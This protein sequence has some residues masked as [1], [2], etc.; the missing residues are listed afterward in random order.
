MLA[1]A[2]GVAGLRTPQ[3]K[4]HSQGTQGTGYTGYHT[5]FRALLGHQ[6]GAGL[7]P[8]PPPPPPPPPSS[9]SSG[10]CLLLLWLPLMIQAL[11]VAVVASVVVQARQGL[12]RRR[13]NIFFVLVDDTGWNNVGYHARSNAAGAEVATPVLDRLVAEGVELTRHVAFKYCSPSRCALQ[14]GRNPIHV[15]VDNDVFAANTGI[16]EPMTCLAEKL[17]ATYVRPA[18]PDFWNAS[19]RVEEWLCGGRSGYRTVF[20]GKWHAGMR[21][22]GQTPR[23]RGYQAAL[24]YFNPDNG[25]FA[26]AQ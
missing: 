9:S 26:Q 1:A 16:P 22:L 19:A 17:A 11:L 23:A 8:P 2:G 15:N 10:R 7:L 18:L 3:G 5:L 21:T 24:N 14:S 20:S 25:W 13:P 12:A 4:G 6:S